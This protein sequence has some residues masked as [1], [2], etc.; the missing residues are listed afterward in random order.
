MTNPEQPVLDEIAELVDWQMEEG[1]KRGD[2]RPEDHVAAMLSV[3]SPE[4]L[5]DINATIAE[6]EQLRG[7]MRGP[8]QVPEDAPYQEWREFQPGERVGWQ[9]PDGTVRVEVVAEHREDPPGSGRW[10][11]TIG[12]VEATP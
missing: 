9:L 6:L 7:G 2:N 12:D 5:A 3:L 11:M 1:R 4:Q 10:T 8:V